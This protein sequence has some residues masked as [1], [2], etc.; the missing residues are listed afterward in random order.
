MSLQDPMLKLKV[1]PSLDPPE[2]FWNVMQPT[3][4]SG[5]SL[6]SWEDLRAGIWRAQG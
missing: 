1:K 3:G 4:T 2:K 6:A 5:V